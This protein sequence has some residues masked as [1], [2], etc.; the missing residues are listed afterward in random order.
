MCKKM[1]GKK[2]IE[3]TVQETETKIYGKCRMCG[4]CCQDIRVDGHFNSKYPGQ[5]LRT[6][7]EDIVKKTIAQ[8]VKENPHLDFSNACGIEIYER[9]G[10]IYCHISGIECK[11]LIKDGKKYKCKFHGKNKP[12]MCKNYPSANSIIRI[13]CGHFKRKIKIKNV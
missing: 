7:F 3:E 8:H 6:N 10:T 4:G 1:K 2:E 11:A 5:F 9:Y 13:G 12:N